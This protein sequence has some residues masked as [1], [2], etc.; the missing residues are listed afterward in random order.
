[1]ATVA[2][3]LHPIA[4]RSAPPTFIG[5]LRIV[6]TS[7]HQPVVLWSPQLLKSHPITFEYSPS[8]SRHRHR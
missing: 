7:C 4:A 3:L 8:L 5:L 2:V 1:M 6:W